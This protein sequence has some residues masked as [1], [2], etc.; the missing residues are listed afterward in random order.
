M[1]LVKRLEEYRERERALTWEGTF[2]H[3]FELA[4][5]RPAVGELSHE[6]IYEMIT[7]AGAE[8]T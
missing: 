8:P 3:Y 2:A 6:R 1:D 4:T 7:A 5:K